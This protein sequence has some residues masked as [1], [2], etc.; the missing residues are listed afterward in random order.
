MGL[1]RA[2]LARFIAVNAR[3]V[4]RGKGTFAGDLHKRQGGEDLIHGFDTHCA[5]CHRARRSPSPP[6][7]VGGALGSHQQLLSKPLGEENP[8]HGAAGGGWPLSQA[9][10]SPGMNLDEVGAAPVPCSELA[11]ALG[12]PHTPPSPTAPFSCA[13]I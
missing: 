3:P 7:P 4:C 8:T 2:I 13:R 12:D 10:G 5:R 1:Q 11:L 9:G 6:V